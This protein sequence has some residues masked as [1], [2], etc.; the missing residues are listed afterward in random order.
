MKDLTHN[1]V[2]WAP[3]ARNEFN[4]KRRRLYR[5]QLGHGPDCNDDLQ[6]EFGT[7]CPEYGWQR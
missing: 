6:H 2:S 1:T 4:P 7:G 5:R 3:L